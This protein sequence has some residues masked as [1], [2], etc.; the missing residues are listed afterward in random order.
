MGRGILC[1]FAPGRF[2]NTFILRILVAQLSNPPGEDD[3]LGSFFVRKCRIYADFRKRGFA[4]N[5]KTWD[6]RLATVMFQGV[7]SLSSIAKFDK[8]S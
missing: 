3:S 6:E 7:D 5:T 8:I 4:V 2:Y 1:S